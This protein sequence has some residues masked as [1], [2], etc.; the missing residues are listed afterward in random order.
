MLKSKTALITGSTSGI[1]LGIAKILANSGCNIVL[2]GFGDKSEIDQLQKSLML[3]FG[4]KI[5]YHEADISKPPMIK[6]MINFANN[7]LG[8]LDILI[9]NAGIQHVAPI[10]NFANEKWD[11]IISINLSGAFHAI[12]AA[13]PLMK[14]NGFGRIINIASAHGLVGSAN[15]AAYVA[16]KHGIVGLTKVTALETAEL[17]ITCNSICPGWVNTPLVEKQITSN[18]SK[19]NI[20]TEQATKNLLSEKQPSLKFVS[21]EE[22]GEAVKFLSSDAAKSIT[23]TSLSIDG[24]WTAR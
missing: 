7:Q 21:V 22:I 23:G 11:E 12:K 24:G 19:E 9:N 18:A 20:T 10:E 6:D 14:N 17:N 16:A 3:E 8:R 2:N 15:K 1:G 5:L 13:L 4:V